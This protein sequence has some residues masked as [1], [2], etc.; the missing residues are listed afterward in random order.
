MVCVTP[1]CDDGGVEFQWFV[2]LSYDD[3]A[4]EF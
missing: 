3:K 4:I 1:S 2:S